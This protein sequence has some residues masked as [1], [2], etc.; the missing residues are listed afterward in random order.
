M[1]RTPIHKRR[2]GTNNSQTIPSRFYIY[3][4]DVDWTTDI[5]VYFH[6]LPNLFEFY[7]TLV[8]TL[9]GADIFGQSAYKVTQKKL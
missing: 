2:Y 9:I 5:Y 4:S 1:I 8:C 7:S 6:N 3:D